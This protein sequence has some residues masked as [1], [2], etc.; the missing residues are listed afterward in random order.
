M[1]RNQELRLGE[2][3]SQVGNTFL[4]GSLGEVQRSK[5]VPIWARIGWEY[6]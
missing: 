2:G 3:Q 1:S 4:K 5:P 6:K